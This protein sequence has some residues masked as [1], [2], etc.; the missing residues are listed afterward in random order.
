MSSCA[1]IL[2]ELTLKGIQRFLKND[3]YFFT[4]KLNFKVCSWDFQFLQKKHQQFKMMNRIIFFAILITGITPFHIDKLEQSP[5]P[6][7]IGASIQ[8][9]CQSTSRFDLCAWQ[10]EGKEGK[11]C[12]VNWDR[13]PVTC[14]N[15]SQTLEVSA[16][17]TNGLCRI[18][19]PKP[20]Q[21]DAGNWTCSLRSEWDKMTVQKLNISVKIEIPLSATTTIKKTSMTTAQAECCCLPV[22]YQ[23]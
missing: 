6:A 16:D 4:R 11:E 21:K 10:K 22:T 14:V 15:F 23:M 17:Y 1:A 8:L 3:K 20:N 7:K 18:T 13:N 5:S 9:D 19:I 12:H 2:V